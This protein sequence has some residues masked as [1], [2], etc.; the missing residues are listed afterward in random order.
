MELKK[1]LK[2][3]VTPYE[4]AKYLKEV[5]GIEVA[6]QRI[7]RDRQDNRL[8]AYRSPAT[9]KWMVTVED[10]TNYILAIKAGGSKKETAW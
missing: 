6:P 9:N 2:R 5:E 8:S 3:D 7:Y 4:I 1:P 10:A